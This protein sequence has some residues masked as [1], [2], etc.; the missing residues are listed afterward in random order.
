VGRLVAAALLLLL[1]F[2]MLIGFLGSSASLSAPATI[3]A[4]LIT[5]GLPA[6][7]GVTLASSHFRQRGQLGRRRDELRRQTI[8]SEILRLAAQHGGRLTA[9]EVASDMAIAP[10]AAKEALDS[11]VLREM[12][13]LEIT[14]SGMLVYAFT[15]IKHLAQKSRAKGVLDA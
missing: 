7:A 4:L 6:A 14:D 13:E 15:D 12:A 11:L 2:F 3:A 8:E 10:E 5:V 1:S 9:V